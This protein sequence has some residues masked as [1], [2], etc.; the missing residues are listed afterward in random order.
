MNSYY[1][2][3]QLAGNVFQRET[4]VEGRRRAERVRPFETELARRRRVLEPLTRPSLAERTFG[5]GLKD[6]PPRLADLLRALRRRG[7]RLRGPPAGLRGLVRRPSRR[8]VR[9]RRT[10][11]ACQAPVR[12]KRQRGLDG[13]SRCEP[14]WVRSSPLPSRSPSPGALTTKDRGPSSSLAIRRALRRRSLA[15]WLRSRRASS[16]RILAVAE[17]ARRRLD[18]TARGARPGPMRWDC[19]RAPLRAEVSSWPSWSM[20]KG[21]AMQDETISARP[22]AVGPQEPAHIPAGCPAPEWPAAAA[23]SRGRAAGCPTSSIISTSAPS[24]WSWPS[25]A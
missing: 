18:Y 11:H 10:G 13:A 7:P 1:A 16:D 4:A 19:P 2:W 9:L 24:P 20:T 12:G 14:E 15:P 17:R 6:D 22:G 23:P 21:S 5:L 25:S 8:M 3:Y